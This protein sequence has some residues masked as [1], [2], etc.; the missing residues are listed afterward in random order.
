MLSPTK[1]GALAGILQPGTPKQSH[2]TEAGG[3][4]IAKKKDVRCRG[5]LYM[6]YLKWLNKNMGFSMAMFEFV[7]WRV[8]IF[9]LWLSLV[10]TYVVPRTRSNFGVLEL[11]SN[12][13]GNVSVRFLFFV[14]FGTFVKDMNRKKS[15]PELIVLNGMLLGLGP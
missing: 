9:F 11:R 15:R 6:A 1:L 12:I 14:L 4:A 3:G 2:C 10:L 8:H 13:P 7:Y 5:Y